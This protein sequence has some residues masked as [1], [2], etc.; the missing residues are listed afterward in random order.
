VNFLPK[1]QAA[2][3]HEDFF[4]DRYDESVTFFANR[5]YRVDPSAYRHPLNQHLISSQRLINK[6]LS[7]ARDYVD[8]HATGF[9]LLPLD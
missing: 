7:L 4:H 3:K 6:F 9:K 1:H 2:L 5:R 8:P